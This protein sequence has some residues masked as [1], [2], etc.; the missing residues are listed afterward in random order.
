MFKRFAICA[1]ALG[2]LASP[3]HAERRV[4]TGSEAQALQCAAFLSYATFV[5][6]RRGLISYRNRE[7]GA[8]AATRIMGQHVSG[9]F[10][11]K[12]AAFQAVL[13]RLPKSEDELMDDTVRHMTWC[14]QRFLS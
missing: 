11:Q 5:M 10:A 3:A 2:V 6:E 12:Q 13:G 9:T 14:T 4:Y 7:E 8:L 1:L